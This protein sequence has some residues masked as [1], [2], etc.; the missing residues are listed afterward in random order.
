MDALAPPLWL[1]YDPAKVPPRADIRPEFGRI[2][3]QLSDDRAVPYVPFFTTES[4]AEKCRDESG[5]P[6]L[7]TLRI[8]NAL[9]LRVILHGLITQS[10]P[11]VRVDDGET[12]DVHTLCRATRWP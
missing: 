3:W 4:L 10:L 9:V 1:L 8:D 5:S 2:I 6:G 12:T 7:A 11:S